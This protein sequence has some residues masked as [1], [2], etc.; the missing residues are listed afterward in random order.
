MRSIREAVAE[1]DI[2]LD[3]SDGDYI[4]DALII[5]T[6]TRADS[7]SRPICIATTEHTSPVVTLGLIES[8]R[9]I[10]DRSAWEPYDDT[11]DD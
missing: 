6:I 9:Q 7:K 1:L 5:C 3:L 10:H 11:A 4:E 2:Q 8:A